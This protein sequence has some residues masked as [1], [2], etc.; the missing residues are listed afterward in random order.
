[1]KNSTI[2]IIELFIFKSV[3]SASYSEKRS[4][5]NSH[6]A[7]CPATRRLNPV[8]PVRNLDAVD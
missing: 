7:V 5:I 4:T 1:M 2:T 6:T 3:Q 8:T